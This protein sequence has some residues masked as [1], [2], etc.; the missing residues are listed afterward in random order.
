M[1]GGFSGCLDGGGASSS[2]FEP[3]DEPEELV[4]SDLDLIHVDEPHI[5]A[6]VMVAGEMEDV[7]HWHQTPLTVGSDEDVIRLW[8]RASE[9]LPGVEAGR[10]DLRARVLEGDVRVEG[11]DGVVEVGGEP[12]ESGVL[13]FEVVA[14]GEAVYVAPPADVEVH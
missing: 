13:E 1:A 3:S 8:G 9:R 4:F 6:F 10:C 14:E 12:G 7:D 2:E 5:E 11:A